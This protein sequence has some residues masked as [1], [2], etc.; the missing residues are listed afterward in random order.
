MYW[1]REAE[2]RLNAEIATY[3]AAGEPIF[4][5][6]FDSE[7][8]ADEENGAK[9][10]LDL[11]NTFPDRNQDLWEMIKGFLADPASGD[12]DQVSKVLK[13]H[14]W[15]FEAARRER[16]KTQYDWGVRMKRPLFHHP[17]PSQSHV[18]GMV[19]FSC[20]AALR[21]HLDGNDAE[22]VEHFRDAMAAGRAMDHLDGFLIAHLV[23]CAIY[24]LI[25]SSIEQV[26]PN[27][28]IGGSSGLGEESRSPADPEAVHALL[29]DLLDEES[30]RT[31]SVRAMQGERAGLFDAYRMIVEEHLP[32]GDLMGLPSSPPSAKE[33]QSWPERSLVWLI[34]PLLTLDAFRMMRLMS[35][36]VEA[37]GAENYE[38]AKRHGA[39]MGIP[40]GLSGALRHP[41]SSTFMPAF[42]RTTVI[43]FRALGARRRAAVGLAARWYAV[44][45]GR[46]PRSVHDLVPA[47]LEAAPLDPMVDDGSLIGLPGWCVEEESD[48]AT[49]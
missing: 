27:L 22:A 24:E 40:S 5:A 17:M 13:E 1:G 47:Y 29:A 37:A 42:G 20:M 4:P 48:E 23:S 30:Y 21:E 14:A 19:R 46:K 34:E 2:R 6:D 7:P 32:W 45:H 11:E 31:G 35:L 39:A 41:L 18:R 9:F 3:R 49:K 15:L 12:S 8:V 10:Y 38:A 25:V 44:D 16:T 43:H 28:A 26:G 36:Q 33:R